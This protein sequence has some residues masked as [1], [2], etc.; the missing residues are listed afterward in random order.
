MLKNNEEK[1]MSKREEQSRK[2]NTQR[3]YDLT[4][5]LR[6]R[7]PNHDD[8]LRLDQILSLIIASPN[9]NFSRNYSLEK[10]SPNQPGKGN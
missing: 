7:F 4:K 5:K 10:L 2:F 1:I 6:K 8:T 3:G 9:R